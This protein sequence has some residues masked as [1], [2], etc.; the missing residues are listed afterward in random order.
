MVKMPRVEHLVLG[1]MALAFVMFLVAAIVI[2]LPFNPLTFNH[3]RVDE[4][5]CAGDQVAI[6]A[7]YTLHEE[8]F[9]SIRSLEVQTAWIAEDVPEVQTGRERIA[10]EI[11][12]GAEQLQP[13]NTQA[14]GRV[15]R[16]VPQEPGLWRLKLRHT[17]RGAPRIQEVET[18]SEN[19]IEVLDE[20]SDECREEGS[21]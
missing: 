3:L 1:V 11:T 14:Q 5:A 2:F 8:D 6:D 13:G 10:S 20:N 4:Q 16:A 21:A 15:P 19:T 17:I 18:V 12:I 7:D 9:D